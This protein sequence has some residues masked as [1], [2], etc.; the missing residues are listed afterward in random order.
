MKH[1]IWMILLTKSICINW[2]GKQ[3]MCIRTNCVFKKITRQENHLQKKFFY[4]I[5]WYI[6]ISSFVTKLKN[7]LNHL[8]YYLCKFETS[9]TMM[10]TK[11]W[12]ETQTIS[13][14]AKSP[15][16]RIISLNHFTT[17]SCEGVLSFYI[18]FIQIK[19]RE[20]RWFHSYVTHV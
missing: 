13:C 2:F 11:L 20:V 10:N 19:L 1:V 3:I 12:F 14:S 4:A 16:V 9:N 8:Q 5:V 15:L 7:F 17:S 18:N 6:G